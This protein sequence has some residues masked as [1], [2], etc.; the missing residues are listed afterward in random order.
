MGYASLVLSTALALVFA[1]SVGSYWVDDAIVFALVS[2]VLF[3]ILSRGPRTE[4][5]FEYGFGPKMTLPRSRIVHYV[6]VSHIRSD[7]STTI[8]SANPFERALLKV[9]GWRT[10][11]AEELKIISRSHRQDPTRITT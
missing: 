6:H 10:L 4:G 8:V 2:C 7:A 1:V 9:Q 5:P 11:S 3:A